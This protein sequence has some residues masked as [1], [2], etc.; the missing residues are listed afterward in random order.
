MFTRFL[1]GEYQ[2]GSFKM[3]TAKLPLWTRLRLYFSKTYCS[4]DQDWGWMMVYKVL[5][6]KTYVI[7]EEQLEVACERPRVWEG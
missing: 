6:G 2:N 7:R 3:V 5:D 4:I 1:T